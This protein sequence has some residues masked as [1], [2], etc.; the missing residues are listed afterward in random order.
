MTAQSSYFRGYAGDIGVAPLINGT[1]NVQDAL[2]AVAAGPVLQPNNT[3][4]AA[5]TPTAITFDG[6]NATFG[7]LVAAPPAWMDN[8]SNIIA[9]GLYQLAVA[10]VAGVAPTTPGQYCAIEFAQAIA[11]VSVDGLAT[12]NAIPTGEMFT[13]GTAD[14]PLAVGVKVATPIDVTGTGSGQVLVTRLAS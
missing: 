13:V 12:D 11:Q 9:A 2:A 7:C 8:A 3:S 5:D 1:D 6:N 10:I 4:V 14:L